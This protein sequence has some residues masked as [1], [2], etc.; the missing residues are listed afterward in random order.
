MKNVM[1]EIQIVTTGKFSFKLPQI[2]GAIKTALLNQALP[3]NR[4]VHKDIHYAQNNATNSKIVYQTL[5]KGI[6]FYF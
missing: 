6:I 1:M 4:Q 3:A 2:L 5:L